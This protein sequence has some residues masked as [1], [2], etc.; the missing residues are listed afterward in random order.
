MRPE[1][2]TIPSERLKEKVLEEVIEL[3]GDEE[4]W[5]FID[6]EDANVEMFNEFGTALKAPGC[7]KYI[8]EAIY[9]E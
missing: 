9:G 8:K 3:Y 6:D 2:S 1:G 5:Y 7:W 4:D